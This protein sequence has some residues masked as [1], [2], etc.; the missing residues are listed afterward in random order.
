MSCILN[1][2]MLATMGAQYA[3]LG[4]PGYALPVR[5]RVRGSGVE[6]AVPIWSGMGD[7]L[8]TTGE[9]TLVVVQYF[10]TTLIVAWLPD[11]IGALLTGRPPTGIEVYTTLVTNV[12]DIGIIGPITLLTIYLMKEAGWGML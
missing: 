9:V 10:A 4:V 3:I 1:T 5:F 2:E 7:L 6:C 8:E 12:L 11:I